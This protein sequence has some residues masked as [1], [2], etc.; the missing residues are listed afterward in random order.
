M[1]LRKNSTCDFIGLN[2]WTSYISNNYTWSSLGQST[3]IQ[4]SCI[5]TVWCSDDT[6]SSL[7]S[8]GKQPWAVDFHLMFLYLYCMTF[9]WHMVIIVVCWKAA[10]G[11]R[12]SSDVLVSV[13]YD[14]PMTHGHHCRLLESSLGQSTFI[15]CSCICT[16]WRSDDTWSSLSSAGKQPWS[17]DFHLM[18]LYLYC[19]TFRWHMVIIVVC[20]K[21]ALVSR[22][23]SDVP[24]SV[25]YE[26]PMTHGHHCRLLEGSL[27]QSTFIWCSCICTVWR[28]DD[29]WS[30]L[31]SAG[32]QPWAVDFHLMFLYLYCMTLRWHMVI[33]V[34]CWKA[35]LGSRLSSDVPVSVLYD[36]P[37]THGH[38]CRLLESSLGQS[39]FIWCSCICT[40]WRSDD[41]WSSL[42]SAGNMKRK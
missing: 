17:V 10:L 22:L 38:H 33:I 37:M 28:S 35:A 34:V 18:F 5:C 26:V 30:S 15:W 31:S 21:A 11:S 12:L 27:G 3:F 20:W 4:C 2:Y 29:T 25:L 41:T 14:V 6:W 8:A 9:R 40:V 19:M 39:T 24:V 36:V 23:S 13:L 7:S 32:R 42:S 1:N 16:V